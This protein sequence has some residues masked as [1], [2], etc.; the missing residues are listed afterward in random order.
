[1]I[2]TTRILRIE[3]VVRNLMASAAFFLP[4]EANALI[5]RNI[6]V[7]PPLGNSSEEGVKKY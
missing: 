6:I 4:V 5:F 1:M 7:P 3:R 2:W